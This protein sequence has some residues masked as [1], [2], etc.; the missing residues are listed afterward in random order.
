VGSRE[1]T[2]VAFPLQAS[3]RTLRT[4]GGH[5]RG[6]LGSV[7]RAHL[8]QLSQT[9]VLKCALRLPMIPGPSGADT[10][11]ARQDFGCHLGD[12]LVLLFAR[13][14]PGPQGAREA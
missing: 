5:P 2:G 4:A 12:A 6:F 3:L 13:L 1:D 9:C 10:R 7:L 11:L 8:P 14:H